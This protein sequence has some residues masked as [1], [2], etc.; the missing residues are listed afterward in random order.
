MSSPACSQV[1]QVGAGTVAASWAV[2]HRGPRG[3]VGDSVV[4]RTGGPVGDA[5]ETFS[6][7][8][9]PDGGKGVF[10]MRKMTDLFTEARKQR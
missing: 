5:M 10:F 7:G 3:C 9:Q 2:S 6:C 4:V 1:G 8:V